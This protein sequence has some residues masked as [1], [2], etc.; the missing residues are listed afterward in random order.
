MAECASESPWRGE[1]SEGEPRRSPRRSLLARDPVKGPWRDRDDRRGDG[2]AGFSERLLASVASRLARE[3]RGSLSS[4]SSS[5]AF[6]FFFFFFLFLLLLL[7]LL[8]LRFLRNKVTAGRSAALKPRAGNGSR[9][10]EAKYARA[11]S[12]RDGG[13]VVGP[14]FVSAYTRFVP[15][16]T[17]KRLDPGHRDRSR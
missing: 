2:I 4:S 17:K 11:L 10:P 15:L 7:L 12:D 1:E 5:L 16:A 3:G 6:L 13:R 9:R 8:L 14:V